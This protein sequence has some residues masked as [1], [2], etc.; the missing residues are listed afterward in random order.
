MTSQ[1]NLE[2]LAKALAQF[3]VEHFDEEYETSGDH[4]RMAAQHFSAAAKHH[5]LAARADDDGDEDSNARHAYLAYQHQLNAVQYAEIAAL[6]TDSMEEELA[7]ENFG[8]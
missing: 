6:N 7:E 1:S 4:H 2:P 3:P 8:A 5:L